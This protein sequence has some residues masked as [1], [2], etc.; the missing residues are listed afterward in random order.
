MQGITI[1]EEFNEEI[2]YLNSF[3]E[4]QLFLKELDFKRIGVIDTSSNR[5]FT[6]LVGE[7]GII[8]HVENGLNEEEVLI[9]ANF[10]RIKNSV[11]N[12]DF[13]SI[14]NHVEIPFKIRLKIF[15]MRWF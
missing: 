12:N 15:F 7:D 11:E 3:K 13:D 4:T 8:Q 6:V 1:T 2:T 5:A 10:A 14:R 9:K